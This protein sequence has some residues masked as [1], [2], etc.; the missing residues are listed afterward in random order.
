MRSNSRIPVSLTEGAP[1]DLAWRVIGLVNIYRLLVAGGLF[2][3]AQS[4]VISEVLGIDRPVPLSII[5][6]AYFVIGIGLIAVRH[7][8]FMGLRLLAFT[9]AVTD[10]IA[11]ALVMWASQGVAGGLGILVLL[12]VGAMALLTG[13]RDAL[14]MASTASIAIQIQQL[15]RDLAPGS[16]EGGYVGAAVLGV[17]IFLAALLVRP[18]ANRLIQSE[19]LVRKQELDLANLAQLSQYIVQRL[20]E[21]MLVVDDQDRIRLINDPAAELLGHANAWPDA[22]LGECSPRLLYLLTAWRQHGDGQEAATF[23]A[24]DGARLVRPHFAHLGTARPGP[25]LIFLEDTSVV[26]E[27]I[28]QSKLAALGRLSA[29]IAHEIRTPI[30]AMSHASQ[31]LAE[32]PQLPVEDKRLTQIIRDNAERVSHIVENVLELSRRGTS[33]PKRI[34]LTSWIGEFWAEFCAT[35]QVGTDAINIAVSPEEGTQLE[36]SADP[37]QLHQIMWNLCQNAITHGLRP[38]G[39]SVEIRFGRIASTGRPFVEVA[40]R[41]PGISAEDMERVFE[42]FFTRAARGTGLGL[43]LAR[44]LA[45]SN[46]ATLLHEARP[47]GG[48]LFRLVF[49]DPG[50]WEE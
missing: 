50:R 30:G 11:I 35:L 17:V 39:E 41:G 45:Q 19:A 6:A 42:P 23:T 9:H 46:G 21:S 44:E 26:A 22:L 15:A 4:E 40:D 5:C 38:G 1:S 48:S 36:I 34:D 14:F 20:R 10:S 16:D 37:T 24:A 43:F 27:K 29:S 7:L 32:S 13:N 18:L 25:V 28:Q 31:L 12:P 2:A 47:E 33:R 49:T 3:A 8:P